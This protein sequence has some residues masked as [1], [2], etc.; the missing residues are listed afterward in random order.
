MTLRIPGAPPSSVDV[1]QHEI[2]AEKVASLGRAGNA[3]ER[4]MAAL[5]AFD[6]DDAAARDELV[7][8][9]ADAVF[10]FMVQRE[11]MG[12]GSHQAAFE[13]YGVT[14]E[15]LARVGVQRSSTR[16]V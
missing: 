5:R 12:S 7:Q 9:A 4:T 2:V 13:T 10:A 1:I 16:R 8:R 3:V 6:G 15:V 14:R 11:L